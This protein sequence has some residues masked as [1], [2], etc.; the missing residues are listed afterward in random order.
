[1]ASSDASLVLETPI[2]SS[3][4][5]L[6]RSCEDNSS[7]RW[8]SHLLAGTPGWLLMPIEA[9]RDIF[10]LHCHASLR[11]LGAELQPPRGG[12]NSEQTPSLI[13]T[14]QTHCSDKKDV[15]GNGERKRVVGKAGAF[16]C[17]LRAQQL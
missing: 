7:G 3:S 15:A 5:S 12:F 6:G 17:K 14:A 4:Q 8:I 11:V 1:M 13:C 9:P 2:P 16:L 10:N